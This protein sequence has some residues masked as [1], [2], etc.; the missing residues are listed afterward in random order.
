MDEQLHKDHRK[1]VREEYLANGFSEATP[2]HKILEMLL[3]YGV[4]RVDT[5]KT[6]HLLLNKFGTFDKVIDAPIE[7]LKKIAGIG[8][9]SAV[10]LK[11]M[12]DVTRLYMKEKTKLDRNKYFSLDDLGK[13]LTGRYIG[14]IKETF[15]VT[16]L[17]SQGGM[18]GFDI[19]AEGEV[20]EVVVSTRNIVETAIKRNATY[21][22]LSHNHPGGEAVPSYKDIETTEKICNILRKRNMHNR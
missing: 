7:E 6:A 5:N 19:I 21:I 17:D 8:E 16:S 9:N 4:S 12:A 18:L 20:G 14:R 11:L 2:P 22:V 3:F 1:R 15:A 10:L 13:F